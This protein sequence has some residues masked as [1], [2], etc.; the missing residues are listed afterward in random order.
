MFVYGCERVI[1]YIDLMSHECIIYHTEKIRNELY[2]SQEELQYICIVAGCDY[3]NNSMSENI[4]IDT[5]YGLYLNYRCE[6]RNDIK[7][8]IEKTTFMKV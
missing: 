5:Y 6:E 1:R 3:T 7:T 8:W 4:P 2:L